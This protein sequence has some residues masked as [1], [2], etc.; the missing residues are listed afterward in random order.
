VAVKWV[1]DDV[2]D[3]LRRYAAGETIQDLKRRYGVDHG[4]IERVLRE[5][6]VPKRWSVEDPNL[7]ELLRLRTEGVLISDL[8]ARFGPCPSA[9]GRLLAKHRVTAPTRWDETSRAAV[10]KAYRDGASELALARNYGCARGVIRKML[11]RAGITP[12]GCGDAMVNRYVGSTPEDRR[13]LTAAAN[14]ALRGKP[15]SP[16][17]RRKS[18]LGRQRTGTFIS[19][20]ENV[21]VA[22]LRRRGLVV[23]QQTAVGPYNCDLTIAAGAVAVEVFGGGW[24]W[25]GGHAARHR[26]RSRY[27]LDQGWH[28]VC[29]V[30]DHRRL[31]AAAGY[32]YLVTFAEFAERNPAARRE[33]RVVG[34]TGQELPGL[35]PD[36]NPITG[37]GPDE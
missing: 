11:L 34:G 1:P 15:L 10:I 29:F 23:E 18:A 4:P 14:A 20:L 30:V 5:H 8:S 2:D 25:S 27:I 6:G 32:D 31:L 12:R 13:A 7:A 28:L 37:V 33:Y 22:E 17:T 19:E 24:H 16:E 36:L 9:I 3:L 26:E 21:I 35:R